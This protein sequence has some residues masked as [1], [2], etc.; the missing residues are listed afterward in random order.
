MRGSTEWYV[1]DEYPPT[2]KRN[3]DA[4]RNIDARDRFIEVNEVR[5]MVTDLKTDV[6]RLT[7]M[8]EELKDA[9]YY[10]PTTGPGYL[11]AAGHWKLATSD[12]N[13]LDKSKVD[14]HT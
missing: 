11:E 5:E 14:H 2:R 3:I 9:L 7:K 10:A 1:A 12:S 8:V 13:V 6:D 4:Q